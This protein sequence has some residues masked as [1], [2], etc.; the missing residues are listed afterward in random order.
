MEAPQK[1]T[2]QPCEK[3]LEYKISCA[4]PNH[5]LVGVPGRAGSCTTSWPSTK[6]RCHLGPIAIF[7]ISNLGMTGCNR[8]NK[9]EEKVDNGCCVLGIL[10]SWRVC[11]LESWQPQAAGAAQGPRL[12]NSRIHTTLTLSYSR[13]RHV[14]TW[15]ASRFV[16]FPASPILFTRLPLEAITNLE[17]KTALP[18]RPA[19]LVASRT[20]N[21][22]HLRAASV[23]PYSG[24]FSAKCLQVGSPFH[25]KLQ[26]R[27]CVDAPMREELASRRQS[28]NLAPFPVRKPH[29]KRISV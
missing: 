1:H 2:P 23:T 26:C 9:E 25:L 18:S 7:A 14:I 29:C 10:E 13:Q 3:I 20:F 12:N 21:S 6:T 8:E 5:Q 4:V 24:F 19:T 17:L 28:A 15:M 16:S 27:R 22:L 11:G